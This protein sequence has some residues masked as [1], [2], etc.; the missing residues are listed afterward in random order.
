MEAW[1]YS[2]SSGRAVVFIISNKTKEIS[3]LFWKPFA[4][5]DSKKYTQSLTRTKKK[6]EKD[7]Q[8]E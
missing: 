7:K 2:T 4:K 5:N 6:N 3:I 1:N 8:T